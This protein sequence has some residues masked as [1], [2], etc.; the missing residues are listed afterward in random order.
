MWLN[1]CHIISLINGLCHSLGLGF[2]TMA[3]VTKESYVANHYAMKVY[4]IY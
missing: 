1:T 4:V 3:Y 2:V